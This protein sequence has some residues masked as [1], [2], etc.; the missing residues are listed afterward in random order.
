[1]IR[2]SARE[3]R[4]DPETGQVFDSKAELRRWHELRLLERAGHICALERQPA[5]ALA[6]NGNPVLIRSERYA[7]G[8]QCTY[9]PDFQYY[10]GPTLIIEEHKGVWTDAARLR[11]AVFEAQ[12]GVRVRLTG[13]AQMMR[14]KR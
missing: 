11:M 12:Y 14:R 4:T 13:P 8:R 5:Y 7:N 9:T 2:R 1:M 10:E 3:D 6:V